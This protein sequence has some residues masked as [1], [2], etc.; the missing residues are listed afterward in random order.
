M[1]DLSAF[2]SR[3]VVRQIVGERT[4]CSWITHESAALLFFGYHVVSR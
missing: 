3:T 2:L 1:D 4:Y